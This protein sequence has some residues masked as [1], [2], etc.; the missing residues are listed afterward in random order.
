MLALC[1]ML[2]GC[3]SDT[4]R[5]PAPELLTF[6]GEA[7]I[8]SQPETP[9]DPRIGG[10]SSIFHVRDDLYYAIS[11]DRGEAGPARYY[12]L[13]IDLSDGRLDDGDAVITGWRELTDA[14]GVPFARGTVDLEGMVAVNGALFVSSEGDASAGVEPFVAVFGE[15]GRMIET[16]G[17]PAGF[18]VTSDRSSGVR[19]NLAFES[20]AITPDDDFLFTATESAL[21]QDGPVATPRAGTLSRIL[22]FDRR[23][24]VFD[25]QFAYPLEPVFAASPLPGAIQVNG[26]T[27][28]L[29]VSYD[30]LLALE[31]AFVAGSLAHS[32]TLFEVCLTGATNIAQ[33]DSLSTTTETVVPA[34]KRFIA[35]LADLVPRL[36]NVEGMTFGPMLDGHRT[37]I[38]VSDDNFAPDRQITQVLAFA[39]SDDA[40]RGCAEH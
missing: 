24:G 14:A 13:R 30:H 11:D 28:L 18:A 12:V 27:E 37:L 22:R 38:F 6:L 40:I 5:P 31:R 1:G 16:L 2:A 21:L 17:L 34:S 8:A 23:H 3:A 20:L 33:I 15:D 19:D 39:L 32:I 36:D 35:D 10:L 4:P 25:A 26:L 7:L 29:A 9:G